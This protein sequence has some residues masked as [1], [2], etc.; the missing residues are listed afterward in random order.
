MRK[1]IYGVMMLAGLAGVAHADE[2][3]TGFYIGAGIGNNQLEESD[4][5]FKFDGDDTAITVFGGYQFNQWIAAEVGYVDGG[6]PS[7]TVGGVN[8]ELDSSAVEVSVI[9]KAQLNRSFSVFARVGL[10]AWDVDAKVSASGG[11]ASISDDGND[12]SYGVG[13]ILSVS[14]SADIRLQW[15]S[16]DLDGVD[17][18]LFDISLIWKF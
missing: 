4:S 16:A 10:L 3:K 11:S 15:R 9:G 18:S 6:K 17:L 7:D 5:G 14:P 8:I 13:G 12:W 1:A 2:A